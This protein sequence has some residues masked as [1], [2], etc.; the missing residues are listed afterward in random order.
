MLGVL[1]PMEMGLHDAGRRR[2]RAQRVGSFTPVV[3]KAAGA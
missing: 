3:A 1:K 2:L